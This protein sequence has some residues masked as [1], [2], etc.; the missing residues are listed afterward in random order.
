M[1]RKNERLKLKISGYSEKEIEEFFAFRE[2][3]EKS[4]S[5][6]VK[7]AFKTDQ[8]YAEDMKL[9]EDNISDCEKRITDLNEKLY[10]ATMPSYI[11]IV[12]NDNKK[13]FDALANIR[14]KAG[15]EAP[16]KNDPRYVP[17]KDAE[18]L[19][20]RLATNPD[21]DAYKKIIQESDT[22]KPNEKQAVYEQ[23]KAQISTIKNNNKVLQTA[24]KSA[25]Q[26][27]LN[28]EI[29]AA[30]VELAES[31]K[32]YQQINKQSKFKDMYDD[33]KRS[34]TT[35]RNL[36]GLTEL[37]NELDS[38][39]A[40]YKK[41]SGIRRFFAHILPAKLYKPAQQYK[42][43]NDLQKLKN[44]ATERDLMD[45]DYMITKENG[46]Y[47]YKN[48]S[49]EALGK[50]NRVQLDLEKSV[51]EPANSKKE[52]VKEEK[53]ADSLEKQLEVPNK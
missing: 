52:F 33:L 20:I 25:N 4:N 53:Q 29:K 26:H 23:A 27:P 12:M 37:D 17:D 39:K 10:D 1:A 28:Q 9:C 5:E 50:T 8:E 45:E 42:E 35:L 22:L 24:M 36:D 30:E 21:I 41:L 7:N 40:E 3:Y 43:I 44:S 38:K 13:C 51:K 15:Y 6:P 32:A 18:N 49:D 48:L 47:V 31:K 34:K 14:E 2:E 19:W 16:N 46:R 11:K